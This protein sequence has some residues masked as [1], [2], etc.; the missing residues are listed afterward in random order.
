MLAILC[1]VMSGGTIVMNRMLNAEQ[2][3]RIGVMQSTVFNYVTGLVTALALLVGFGAWRG[4]GL[5]G[6][7]WLYLGGMIGVG[8]VAMS[9]LAAPHLPVFLMT[10]VMFVSQFGAGM[11]LD[12]L[13]GVGEGG[14]RIAGAALVV[15]GLLVYVLGER[16]TAPIEAREASRESRGQRPLDLG[17]RS[18]VASA[19]SRIV[20][21]IGPH[22]PT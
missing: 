7:W 2:G 10:L 12:A 6:A 21:C 9:S 5:P 3:T 13:K 19:A 8:V 15:L 14:W 4:V 22:A 16:N 1:A 18:S 20:R 17:G 11:V